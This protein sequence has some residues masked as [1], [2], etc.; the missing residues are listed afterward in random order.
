MDFE[1]EEKMYNIWKILFL[2]KKISHFL[3]H[4]YMQDAE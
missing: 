3:K 1:M 2:E 4:I